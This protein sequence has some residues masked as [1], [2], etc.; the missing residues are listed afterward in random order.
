MAWIIRGALTEM[1][2]SGQEEHS[3]I[4]NYLEG[5]D[6]LKTI[7]LCWQI[8]ATFDGYLNYRPK[9]IN[10][11]TKNKR[12]SRSEDEEWQYYLWNKIADAMPCQPLHKLVREE[13][14]GS[15]GPSR[16]WLFGISHLPPVPYKHYRTS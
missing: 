1:L 8:A 15:G 13:T 12:N 2:R 14:F 7:Q 5:I 9:L 16:L 3:P 10:R 6:P 4:A 11:W